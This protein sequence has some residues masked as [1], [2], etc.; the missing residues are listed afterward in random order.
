MLGVISAKKRLGDGRIVCVRGNPRGT[1]TGMNGGGF[2]D[3][4]TD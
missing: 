2:A 4:N 1:Q 3:W